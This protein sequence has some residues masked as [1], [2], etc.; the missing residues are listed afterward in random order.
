MAIYKL[1]ES[2]YGNE[3]IERVITGYKREEDED[4]WTI[5]TSDETE[6]I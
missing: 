5:E 4:L 2:K 6:D 3:Q 1:A